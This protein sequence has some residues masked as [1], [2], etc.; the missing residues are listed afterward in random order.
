MSLVFAEERY[1]DAIEEMRLMYPAHWAEIEKDADTIPLDMDYERY[2]LLERLGIIHLVTARIDGRMVGYHLFCVSPHLHHKS[3]LTA[4]SD[5]FYLKPSYRKG[6]NGI[7]FLRFAESSLKARGV[8]RAA[9]ES[10]MRRDFGVILRFLG[11]GVMGHLYS[12]VL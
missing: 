11:W 3:S 9:M 10:T 4:V 6:F 1:S 7:N 12:K 8:Q 2:E 5:I